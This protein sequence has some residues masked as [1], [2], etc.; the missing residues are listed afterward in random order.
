MNNNIIIQYKLLGSYMKNSDLFLGI[1]NLVRPNIFTT[2]VTKKSY[3]VIKIYHSKNVEPDTTLIFKALHK[4]GL[5]QSDCAEVAKFDT[6][7]YLSSEHVKEYVES[8]FSDYVR[9]YIA[10]S[11]QGFILN[12][13]SADPLDQMIKLKDAI[14]NVELSLNNVSKDRSILDVFDEAYEEI[15]GLKNGTIQDIIYS[16]GIKELDNKT[17][18]ISD[19]PNILAATPGSGKTSMV[20]NLA[21]V[22]CV[23]NNLPFLFFS[24]EM[25]AKDLMKNIISNMVEINSRSIREGNIDDE[26][27]L[28]IQSV[29]GKLKE[30]FEI[31]ETDSITWQY[32]ESKVK[33]FRK[34]K[35]IPTKVAILV[36]IDFIQKMTS[37]LEETRGIND[38]KQVDVRMNQLARIAKQENLKLIEIS[39]FTRET[40]KRDKPRPKLTDLKGSS[41]I[42]QN[43]VT[44]LLMYRPDQ[45]GILTNDSGIDLKGI[46]EINIA[47]AR[48]SVTE[49]VY[50]RFE[51]KYSKF[52]DHEMYTNNGIITSGEESF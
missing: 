11:A 20:I 46:V 36:A 43:A 52:I 33:S 24:L 26:Q 22:N 1:E 40:S 5:N 32:F 31:D 3:E 18:G 21:I 44:A 19:G 28:S 37:V 8:L 23:Y 47:K 12:K 50:A 38:E 42:E 16:W 48:F 15:V 25:K 27:L 29:R 39:Q 35:N 4:Y 13:D 14:T 17:G 30:Q 51:G 9:E 45:H 34:K 41:S 10:K 2:S 49:P 7:Y 6:S